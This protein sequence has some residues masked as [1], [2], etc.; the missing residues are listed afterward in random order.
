MRQR[1]CAAHQP[2]G[3]EKR[4]AQRRWQLLKQLEDWIAPVPILP[5]PEQ[6]APPLAEIVA[7]STARHAALTLNR[8]LRRNPQRWTAASLQRLLIELF[9]IYAIAGSP[10]HHAKEARAWPLAH[11]TA[12]PASQRS[13]V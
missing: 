7:Q 8:A 5:I 1:Q 11:R 12:A 9:T 4:H 10:E 3:D 13:R 2:N 6:R